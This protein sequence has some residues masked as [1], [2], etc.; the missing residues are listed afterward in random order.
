MNYTLPGKKLNIETLQKIMQSNALLYCAVLLLALK[1]ILVGISVNF[2]QNIFFADITKSALQIFVN[3]T[4]QSAGLK[5]LAE[6]AKL[7]QAAQLKAENMVQNQYFAHTSPSGVSPWH[8][9]LKAGYNYKYAGENLAIGFFESLEVYQAWL[10]SPSHK[11]NIMN[12]NY[13]EIGTA[14]IQGYGQNNAIVVVQE[15]GN[16]VIA[17]QAPV[18]NIQSSASG[19]SSS[20]APVSA[21]PSAAPAVQP[22]DKKVLSQQTELVPATINMILKNIVYGFSLVMIGVLILS[23][24]FKSPIENRRNLAFRAF[25]VII[26]LSATA[27]VNAEAAASLTP[28]KITI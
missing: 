5:P 1:I 21:P 9:F 11:A 20:T 28:H 4:R 10:N 6:S 3:Q 23:V 26:I 7:N 27:M 22:I 12:P 14:V 13:T 16:P 24:L 25:A 15:F 19:T 2:P 8:W 18:S 17:K